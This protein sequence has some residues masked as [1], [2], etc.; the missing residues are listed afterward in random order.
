M[1]G[2]GVKVGGA[3]SVEMGWIGVGWGVMCHGEG[4]C[5]VLGMLAP[6]VRAPQFLRNWCYSS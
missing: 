4:W 3:L 2:V 6:S 5:A 1:G